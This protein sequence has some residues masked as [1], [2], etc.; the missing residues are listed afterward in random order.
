MNGSNKLI[1]YKYSRWSS[2]ALIVA[3]TCFTWVGV[4]VGADDLLP[5]AGSVNRDAPTQKL[6][7]ETNLSGDDAQH[8]GSFTLEYRPIHFSESAFKTVMENEGTRKFYTE[9]YLTKIARI[10]VKGGV[11][12]KNFTIP[13]GTH[14]LALTT[15]GT[16]WF[17]DVT[18]ED[19]KSQLDG[20]QKVWLGD[21]PVASDRMFMALQP[22]KESYRASLRIIYGGHAIPLYFNVGKPYSAGESSSGTSQ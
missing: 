2:L 21:S 11:Y 15:D 9:R 5:V 17:I 10:T 3:M 19:G 12:T 20:K 1:P 22:M 8:N 6:V 14:Y 4:A 7:F 13:E 16:D 18:D